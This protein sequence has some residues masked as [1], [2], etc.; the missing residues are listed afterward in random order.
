MVELGEELLGFEAIDAGVDFGSVAL[1]WSEGFL[2][3]DGGD[4]FRT[5][6][7]TKDA[8]VAGGVGRD[9]GEDG[10]GGVLLEVGFGEG[11]E[12]FGADE[13]GVAGED[14]EML[15]RGGRAGLGEEGFDRLE[16]VAGSAL[17]G[18][19]DERDAGVGD[20]GFHAG[21]L[22]A[23]DDEDAV[24]GDERAG[25][26]DD[27]EQEGLAADLVEDLGA[28]AFETG[29][30]AGGHNGDGEGGEV[31]VRWGCHGAY[32]LTRRG[33]WRRILVV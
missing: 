7:S 22:M 19:V 33:V 24:G 11:V 16:G 31:G 14:E 12:G 30:L 25:G 9:G 27:V 3:D 2:L 23:G 6:A 13:G 32:F 15:G 21:R 18:L 5:G 20:G 29:A 17:L 28:F 4:V 1:F 26:G 8:A 10:H